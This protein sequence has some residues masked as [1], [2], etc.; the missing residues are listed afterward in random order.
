MNNK[1]F[2]IPKILCFP[3]MHG[4]FLLGNNFISNSLPMQIHHKFVAITLKKELVNI[5]I[6]EQHKYKCLSDFTLAK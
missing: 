6:L 2:V 5:P 3:N 4:D 1:K